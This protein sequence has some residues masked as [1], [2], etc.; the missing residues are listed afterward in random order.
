M[1]ILLAP[2]KFRGALT[3]AEAAAAMAAGARDVAPDCEL[4][5]C[6][7]GDGGEGSGEILADALRCTRESTVVFD[8]LGRPRAAAWWRS[9]DGEVAIVEMAQASGLGLLAL[10]DRLPLRTTS[11]GT[12]QLLRTVELRGS[13]RIQLCVGGSATVDGGAG[14]LQAL[15]WGLLDD[16]GREIETAVA[17]GQLL[18]VADLRPPDAPY[19]GDITVLCDVD[20]PLTG[21]RGAAPVFAPQKG[22]S[23]E[24]VARLQ[25]GLEHWADVLARRTGRDVRSLAHGGAAGGL[26]AALYACCNAR[27]VAGAAAIGDSLRLR[28]R[29]RAADMILTGEGRLDAQTAGGKVVAEVG[30]LAR[31]AGR[32]AVAFVGQFAAPSGSDLQRAAAELGLCDIIEIAA[33]GRPRPLAL[34]RCAD[35]L[36]AAAA[37]FLR[38]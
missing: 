3:A 14:C 31:E 19:C 38:R 28:Q 5:V 34:R 32:P 1:R 25:R 8:P 37:R 33:R 9:R 23:P 11:F 16:H 15:G 27:L 35:D 29:V 13:R 36:R 12:G 30:R 10:H 20:H 4:D 18:D 22:A 7:M 24:Q 21:P 26:P 2:D 17:G 6:P